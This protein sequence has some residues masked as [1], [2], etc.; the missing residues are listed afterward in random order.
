M[1]YRSTSLPTI[2]P[3]DSGGLMEGSYTGHEGSWGSYTQEIK[4][5]RKKA[6]DDIRNEASLEAR[7]QLENDM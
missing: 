4:E 5:I 6:L 2:Q 1:T 7:L 3:T